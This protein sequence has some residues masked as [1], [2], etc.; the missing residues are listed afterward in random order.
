M[1]RSRVVAAV[2]ALI[3]AVSSTAALWWVFESVTSYPELPA[4]ASTISITYAKP[5]NADSVG[6]EFSDDLG[7]VPATVDLYVALSNDSLAR[8]DDPA[9][10]YLR[11]PAF[12]D[13]TLLGQECQVTIRRGTGRCSVVDDA[14]VITAAVPAGGLSIGVP[15]SWSFSGFKSDIFSLPEVQANGTGT[16]P[17]RTVDASKVYV[18]LAR[19]HS[20]DAEIA[21]S[22]T[23]SPSERLDNVDPAPQ[24]SGS[25]FWT[26]T[27]GATSGPRGTITDVTADGLQGRIVFVLGV[28]L[29]MIPLMAGAVYKLSLWAQRGCTSITRG[30][31]VTP[32]DPSTAS[33]EQRR[34]RRPAPLGSRPSRRSRR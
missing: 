9:T 2:L 33:V 16:L 15:K 1:V 11:G 7:D 28:V 4:K 18:L 23:L 8:G 17:Q 6:A 34:R 21:P 14:Q 12:T 27:G 32:V 29:G 19:T 31:A 13:G 25:L 5:A 26:M 3:V 22:N 24:F 30:Q 20:R 10:I